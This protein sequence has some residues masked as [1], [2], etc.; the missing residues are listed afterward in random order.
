MWLITCP[1][2]LNDFTT[3]GSWSFANVISDGLIQGQDHGNTPAA[4]AMENAELLM[5]KWFFATIVM[6]CMVSRV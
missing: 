1:S 2:S 6:P 5:T 3:L 4:N